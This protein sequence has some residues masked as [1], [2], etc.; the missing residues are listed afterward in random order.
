MTAAVT[1]S[2]RTNKNQVADKPDNAHIMFTLRQLKYFVAVAKHGNI[3]TAA[4]SL[5]VSQPGVSTAIAQL[6]EMFDVQLFVRQRARGVTL[7]PAGRALMASAIELLNHVSDVM[8]LGS[9]LDDSVKGPLRIGFYHTIGPYLLPGL[10]RHFHDLY[11][12]VD[13][14][15]TEGNL[16]ELHLALSSS[17]IELAILYD[18]D[19][20]EQFAHVHLMGLPPYVLVAANSDLASRQ[21]VSIHELTQ[22]PMVLLDLPHSSEYFRML[23]L[24]MNVKPRISYRTRSVSMVRSLVANGFGY[25]ILNFQ[26]TVRTDNDG[27]PLAYLRIKENFPSLDVLLAWP[28]GVH[29]TRRARNFI[30]IAQAYT[31]K[32]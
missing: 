2:I 12:L 28:R 32:P 10:L 24:T 11:P 3:T 14:S 23:F 5:H 29:L 6:E 8:T 21:E 30:E 16:A 27:M 13:I 19:L 9:S 4:E 15:L 31:Q 25:S 17:D 18:L 22:E 1:Q 26:A 20:P 7:T